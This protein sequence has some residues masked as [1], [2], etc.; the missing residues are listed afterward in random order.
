VICE[1]AGVLLMGWDFH[2]EAAG[3]LR[4]RPFIIDAVVAL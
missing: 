2:S 1:F 3:I 4:G